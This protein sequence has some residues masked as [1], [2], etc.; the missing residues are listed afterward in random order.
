MSEGNSGPVERLTGTAAMALQL[1]LVGVAMRTRGAAISR[2]S[3]Q[4]H[5]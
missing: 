3:P 2:K 5:N 4:Y 1:F